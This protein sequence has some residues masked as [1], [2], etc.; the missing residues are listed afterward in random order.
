MVNRKP[1]T[2]KFLDTIVEHPTFGEALDA[3]RRAH[4]TSGVKPK[5]TIIF[6]DSGVGKTTLIDE[7][8]RDHPRTEEIDGTRVPVIAIET[9]SAQNV[10]AITEEL[11]DALGVPYP[12]RS[13][14]K[15]LFRIMKRAFEDL[16]VELVFFDEFQEVLPQ[17]TKDSPHIMRFIK[18]AMNETKIPWVL[19]GTDQTQKVLEMGDNQ[20]RRRFSGAYRLKPFSIRTQQDRE[21]F[22]TYISFLQSALPFECR[23]LTEEI[24]L[25]R[26]YLTTSGIPGFIANLFEQLVEIHEG[27]GPVTLK[28]LAEAH[29]RA[30]IGSGDT[31]AGAFMAQNPF[32]LT[33]QRVTDIAGGM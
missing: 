5:G 23:H 20:L 9:D 24:H 8:L 19:V 14:Q 15:S 17:K 12:S 30:F 7:Y 29:R 27:D 21:N 28:L 25:S 2:L 4:A 16:G 6:G 13:T 11:L 26:I 33:A 10:K 31:T 32:N 18:R 3:V 1:E 22:K